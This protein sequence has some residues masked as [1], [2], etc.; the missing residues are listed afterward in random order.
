MSALKTNVYV[1]SNGADPQYTFD[2]EKEI[3]IKSWN[4]QLAGVGYFTGNDIKGRLVI[5][6]PSL[7]SLI[8]ISEKK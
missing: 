6:N 3:F 7:C 1:C 8:E 4:N 2:L 5:I